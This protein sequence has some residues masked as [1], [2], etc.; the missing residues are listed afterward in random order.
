MEIKTDTVWISLCDRY[1][2]SSKRSH[3]HCSSVLALQV[4]NSTTAAKVTDS[5][6]FKV[7]CRDHSNS[8]EVILSASNSRCK[9]GPLRRVNFLAPRWHCSRSTVALIWRSRR[10]CTVESV[11]Y[12]HYEEANEASHHGCGYGVNFLAPRWHCSRSTVAL[13]WRSRKDCTVESVEYQHYEEANEASHHGCGYG[14]NFLAPRWHCSR[15]TVAL[16]WRSRRDCTVESVEYQHYE[17]ANEASHHGCGYGVNFLAP[18]WHCSR[19]T[20]AL[21]WRSRKDCTVESVE[22]QH[23]EEAN[24]ASHHGCGY[25]YIE[26]GERHDSLISPGVFHCECGT[27]ER[28]RVNRRDNC[29]RMQASSRVFSVS[30]SRCNDGPLRRVNFLAPCS[31][32]SGSI[33]RPAALIWCKG[34]M[35][36][37]FEAV[38][39][40]YREK[41]HHG[42]EYG[43]KKQIHV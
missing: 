33:T 3:I 38:K 30:N 14:V 11:E 29:E 39:Y 17:E 27:P 40:K 19:S 35:D 16:I 24:E 5:L 20:V 18:R 4:C 32:C 23:Y 15:S 21:I 12:Q 1:E 34:L 26:N 28:C 25:A 7:S 8:E 36:C 9:D 37:T 6:E 13:I 10:D 42:C 31:H 41:A 2:K 22:Y 43:A